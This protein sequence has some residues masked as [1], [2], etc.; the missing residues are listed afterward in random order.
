MRVPCTPSELAAIMGR[1]KRHIRACLYYMRG[2]GYV[3]RLDRSI[4]VENKRRVNKEFLWI[5]Q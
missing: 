4:P 5:S 3:Q 1:S 2:M